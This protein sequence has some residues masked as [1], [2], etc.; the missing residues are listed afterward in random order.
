MAAA[1]N[2]LLPVVLA[3]VVLAVAAL[4]A[5]R[6]LGAAGP[7]LAA[8]LP[9]HAAVVGAWFVRVR[10]ELAEARR[11]PVT[12]LFVRRVAERHL[13]RVRGPVTVALLDADDLR[14]VNTRFGHAGGDALLAALGQRLC[15][16]AVAGDVVAR[17]GGDEFVLISHRPVVAVH[18]GLLAALAAPVTLFGCVVP[19][20]VSVGICRSAGG[21]HRRALARADRLMYVAKRHGGGIVHL[22][23]PP[24]NAPR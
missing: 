6:V 15:A 19:M 24:V 7:V 17:L 8:L 2:G 9:A 1:V 4:V 18:R 5:D 13:D 16:A 12:E 10:A 3:D 14:G 11:D 22:S 20:K 21:D 23:S